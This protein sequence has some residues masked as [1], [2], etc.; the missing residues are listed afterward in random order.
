MNQTFSK[1]GQSLFLAGVSVCAFA[2]SSYGQIPVIKKS[3]LKKSTTETTAE[4]PG[5]SAD[6]TDVSRVEVPKVSSRKG[7]RVIPIQPT[8]LGSKSSQRII[9]ITPKADA[10][11]VP[12]LSTS[13]EGRKVGSEEAIRTAEHQPE[14]QPVKTTAENSDTTKE[15]VARG[16]S[17]VIPIQSSNEPRKL[18]EFATGYDS[19]A[20]SDVI[21]KTSG[22]LLPVNSSSGSA[23]LNPITQQHQHQQ[24]QQQ[25]QQ[26]QLGWQRAIPAP[27]KSMQ[28]GMPVTPPTLQPLPQDT[29][30][31]PFGLSGYS[32]ATQPVPTPPPAIDNAP[33]GNSYLQAPMPD[34]Q[35]LM[36]EA[37]CDSS[38]GCDG[39]GCGSSSCT[40]CLSLGLC[41]LGGSG[42]AGLMDRHVNG[43]SVW[44][45]PSLLGGISHVGFE[46]CGY[47]CGARHY[48]QADALY[49]RRS[50]GGIIGTNF[51][52]PDDAEWELG[53]RGTIGWRQD[54]I[55]GYEANYFGFQPMQ[56]VVRQNSAG[57]AID[58]QF[59][60]RGGLTTTHLDSFF[61]ANQTQ[62]TL[63]T[64]FHS[65]EFSRVRFGW[66]VLKTS[67][68]MRYI[69]LDDQYDLASQSG[70]DIGL[71]RLKAN[72]NLIGPT[73]GLELLYDVSRRISYS[74][75]AKGGAYLD[76]TRL[77]TNL[78]DGA[79]QFIQNSN[80]QTDLAA[81][82]ELG[83]NAYLKLTH[84]VRLRGGYDALWL[85]NVMSVAENYP[86]FMTPLTGRNPD[87]SRRVDLHGVSF[88]IEFF[89]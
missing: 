85:Y 89:R 38:G 55:V 36:A 86:V 14:I 71:F 16:S 44:C 72:N 21:Q 52:G 83:A 59:S 26:Q 19:S 61:D 4:S 3:E 60:P 22:I 46:N 41:G 56:E 77:N 11:I 28:P 9:P 13:V 68:G 39:G 49:W 65:V 34:G 45:R 17:R 47:I 75:R 27:P 50:D 6:T 58:A 32:R 67:V 54:E 40:S 30:H 29:G 78:A 31:S 81:S 70:A 35:L 57:G 76:F 15:K 69:W 63:Q 53:W 12:E 84:N 42:R 79:N 87:D 82:L 33:V 18:A 88:G 43:S 25:Q 5:G 66:D 51:G 37:G 62:Q 23:P 64:R 7:S 1:I 20:D 48:F 24:Q 2:Q 73:V 74:A 8:E 10:N 80:T